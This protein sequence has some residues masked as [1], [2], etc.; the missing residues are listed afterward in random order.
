M[1]VGTIADLP[2]L[3]EYYNS[4]LGWNKYHHMQA[5]G[6]QIMVTRYDRRVLTH[7]IAT[8]SSLSY[9]VQFRDSS[10]GW[11]GL[12]VDLYG[13]VLANYALIT[14]YAAE[15]LIGKVN[16]VVDAK[17]DRYGV[18]VTKAI[19]RGY[20][21]GFH[22][23]HGEWL[24]YKNGDSDFPKHEVSATEVNT[25]CNSFVFQSE[26][27]MKIKAHGYQRDHGE[28]RIWKESSKESAIADASN[29]TEV[30]T[31]LVSCG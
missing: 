7:A 3:E 22:V 29:D 30:T 4:P 24:R 2:D 15:I 25:T 1:Y 16:D 5:A 23:P 8:M 11:L 19:D 21:R 10:E 18:I 9:Y 31:R 12:S 20:V 28:V 14:G 6:N 13:L 17:S 27:G 26:Q